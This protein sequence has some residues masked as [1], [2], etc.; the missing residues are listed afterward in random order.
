[1]DVCE[2]TFEELLADCARERRMLSGRWRHR[3]DDVDAEI[4]AAMWEAYANGSRTTAELVRAADNCCRNRARAAGRFHATGA[5]LAGGD[6]R[7]LLGWRSS[8]RV[9]R[10][11]EL[12]P[13]AHQVTVE[14][15]LVDRLTA[16]Q[17]IGP[18]SLLPPAVASWAN[19]LTKSGLTAAELERCRR[20]RIAMKQQLTKEHRNHE[21]A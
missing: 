20:W 19:P 6:V 9:A 7:S 10:Y 18:L 17:L 15:E 13:T 8:Q 12:S 14:D 3:T 2:I 4:D 16:A 5:V 1:M 21:A 11:A